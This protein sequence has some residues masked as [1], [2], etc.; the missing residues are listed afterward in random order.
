MPCN[1]N[2]PLDN[3]AKCSNNDY[4]KTNDH[5]EIEPI[6]IEVIKSYKTTNDV[7]VKHHVKEKEVVISEINLSDIYGASRSYFYQ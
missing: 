5:S 2:S 4:S 3:T 6:D 1:N 7:I